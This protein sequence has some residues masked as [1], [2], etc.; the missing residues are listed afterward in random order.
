MWPWLIASEH[1]IFFLFSYLHQ[2]GDDGDD[3]DHVLCGLVCF[4]RCSSHS[5][6]LNQR[7]K[8][9]RPRPFRR[10]PQCGTLNHCCSVEPL[11]EMW[12][13]QGGW[14]TFT[15]PLWSA[16]GSRCST[17]P[18]MFTAES[19]SHLRRGGV[20]RC[21]CVMS[22]QH[23]WK[24]LLRFQLPVGVLEDSVGPDSEDPV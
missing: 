11:G 18:V 14:P 1:V 6:H 15:P 21:R 13:S 16:G 8:W 3:D 24:T 5:K 22:S 12:G 20:Y 7:G 4:L 9:I 2:R 17:Q 23:R 10:E 19:T